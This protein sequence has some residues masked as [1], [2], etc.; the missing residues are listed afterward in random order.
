MINP[1]RS[2]RCPC[3]LPSSSH[4][5]VPEEWLTPNCPVRDPTRGITKIAAA[6][7]H[8]RAR[9]RVICT[10][11][12]VACYGLLTGSCRSMA[13]VGTLK[14]NSVQH[15]WRLAAPASGRKIQVPMGTR[16]SMVQRSTQLKE[17][18]KTL[19][20]LACPNWTI[21][22]LYTQTAWATSMVLLTVINNGCASSLLPHLSIIRAYCAPLLH[23][24]FRCLAA[25]R[26]TH[27]R[28]YCLCPKQ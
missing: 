18:R 24:E 10:S 14:A 9:A 20:T 13:L 5:S 7:R 25:C 26:C 8:D 3:R 11:R 12:P 23:N 21:P 4:G 22:V 16:A 27:R 17:A 1:V 19:V 15:A 6:A 28:L 2:S